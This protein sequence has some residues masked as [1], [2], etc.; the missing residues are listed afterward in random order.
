MGFVRKLSLQ[1]LSKR[2]LC[3]HKAD[4]WLLVYLRVLLYNAL[5]EF[6]SFCRDLFKNLK[7]MIKMMC[8]SL[9]ADVLL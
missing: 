1:T 3:L 5:K 8:I 9:R 4:L 2:I 7:P 6:I